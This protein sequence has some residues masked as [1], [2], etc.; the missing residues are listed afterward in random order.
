MLG[1]EVPPVRKA[2]WRTGP[3]LSPLGTSVY[4]EPEK[5]VLQCKR[6]CEKHSQ[7]LQEHNSNQQKCQWI[8]KK[9]AC[10]YLSILVLPNNFIQCLLYIKD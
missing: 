3:S 10:L 8:E 6:L 7:N 2:V 1:L 4:E 9:D 5:E